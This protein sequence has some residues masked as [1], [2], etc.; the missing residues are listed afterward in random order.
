ML[1]GCFIVWYRLV[2][3]ILTV[4]RQS[5]GPGA[6]SLYHP[7]PCF[8]SHY[9]TRTFQCLHYLDMKMSEWICFTFPPPGLFRPLEVYLI[10]QYFLFL[11]SLMIKSPVLFDFMSV[12]CRSP[13]KSQ[14]RPINFIPITGPSLCNRNCGENNNLPRVGSPQLM[15]T[16][17]NLVSQCTKRG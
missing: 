12:P 6:L 1:N 5:L 14:R 15:C 9:D 2:F 13:L 17:T 11:I 4:A 3:I 16:E 10:F 7:G 8:A